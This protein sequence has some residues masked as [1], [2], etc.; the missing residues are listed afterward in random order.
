[1]NQETINIRGSLQANPSGSGA[2][3][4]NYG[5]IIITILG[6]SDGTDGQELWDDGG[7]WWPDRF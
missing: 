6:V 4:I 2:Y 3:I 7:A 1:L 5:T